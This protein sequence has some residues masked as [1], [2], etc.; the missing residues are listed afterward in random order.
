MPQRTTN[1]PAD[2]R[3]LISSDGKSLLIYGVIG[4]WWEGN[5]ALT[6]AREIDELAASM[7]EINVR[8]HS[9]GGFIM[10]GLVVYNRLKHC[11]K[12][13]NIHIDGMAA[14][15]A[16]VIAMA[17]GNGGKITMPRN[18]WLMIHKPINSVWSG[19]AEDFRKMADTLDGF[20]AD[21]T[22][23]YMDRYT[24]TQDE[25]SEMLAEETWINAQDAL[26]LG[27]IDEIVEPVQA[28]AIALDDFQNAP[29]E[30]KALFGEQPANTAKST[31]GGTKMP[32]SVNGQ[33]Q[34]P[35]ANSGADEPIQ[36]PAAASAAV[37]GFDVGDAV[38]D[39]VN[40]ALAART[41][42]NA[43][44]EALAKSVRLSATETSAIV[45]Q[46]LN[47][48]DA[49]A[50]IL[51]VVAQRDASNQPVPYVTVSND[52]STLREDVAAGLMVRAGLADSKEGNDF[53]QMSLAEVAR[54]VLQACGISTHGLSNSAVASQAM[55]TVSDFPNIL[56]DVANKSLRV[57]YDGYPRTFLP[58]SR[59][60]TATDFKTINRMQLGEA[61]ELKKVNE[62]GE[63]THGTLGDGKESYA[64]ETYG[65]IISLTRKT[66]IN[67]DLDALTRIPQ[68]F[69]DAAADLEN[70]TVWGLITKNGKMA[71]NKALFHA[72]HNNLGTA[73]ALSETTLSEMRK[74][75]RTQKGM[76]ADRPLNLRAQYLIVPAALET[77]AQ[78][79]LSAIMA[80]Q[81]AEVNVFANTLELI[82]EP[83]L[84]A[85]SEKSWYASASPS[86]IDTIEYAYLSG[87]EGVFIETQ[88]GFEVD[89]IK[90]KAMLDFGAGV[91][92]HR[93][94]FKNAGA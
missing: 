72:D 29:T 41:K 12:P 61:P 75:L 32:M 90:I 67:D 31:V 48:E 60:V 77:A 40:A 92:D 94:L 52:T 1:N 56:A 14:S 69:G 25:L 65:R 74:M 33:A 19:N 27:F 38:T 82:A 83:L 85:A 59:R 35:A 55:H 88:S 87:N 8:I 47:M 30:V 80:T 50:A 62:K 7:D 44:I 5:D 28:A 42:L 66:I 16:S 37:E 78:K 36:T 15:M 73:G 79:L 11:G 84:D 71:D 45:A 39:A 24:G 4:D 3:L 70:R 2:S 49:R 23:I 64:L 21:I 93:G 43:D 46:N 20:E 54:F 63:Y 13:V 18:A 51:S 76:N 6:L 57:G 58:F 10:E 9:P 17:G 81:T 26:T 86:R 53:T 91:I 89:G 34:N 22:N 68:S